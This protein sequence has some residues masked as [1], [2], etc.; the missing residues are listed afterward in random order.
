MVSMRATPDIT[1]PR[2]LVPT[3]EQLRALQRMFGFEGSAVVVTL[4]PPPE[5]AVLR[6]VHGMAR[7][8]EAMAG[9]L[10][11]MRKEVRAL[12]GAKR[13]GAERLSQDIAR[14]AFALLQKLELDAPLKSPSVLTV[15]RL[16]CVDGLSA[17]QV[18][19]KCR[20]AKGTVM[21]RLRFIEKVTKSKPEQF[22]V[23]S[24]HLQRLNDDLNAS[25]AREIY[26]RGLVGNDEG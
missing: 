6:E 15:F 22:R 4:P 8:M 19:R 11:G 5:S 12:R 16:Y 20:C 21:S 1:Q 13:P 17:D 25:G 7:A 10:V 26:R 24:G 2:V 3:A 14:N 9:D 23:V 18:A